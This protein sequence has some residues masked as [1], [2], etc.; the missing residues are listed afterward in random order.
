MPNLFVRVALGRANHGRQSEAQSYFGYT[1]ASI[2]LFVETEGTPDQS[3][4][5]YKNDIQDCRCSG[6]F[7]P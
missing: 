3:K 4:I 1:L 2:N 5:P 6:S 7:I